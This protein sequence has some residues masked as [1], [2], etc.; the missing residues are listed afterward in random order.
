MTTTNTIGA[1][2][3]YDTEPR[4]YHALKPWL[5]IARRL[6][7][8]ARESGT[9]SVISITVISSPGGIPIAWTNPK[10]TT[11]RIEVRA[12]EKGHALDTLLCALGE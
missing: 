9:Y 11:K 4:D 12:D 1:K 8:V 5:N 10:S 7:Q 6:R 3:A 2:I